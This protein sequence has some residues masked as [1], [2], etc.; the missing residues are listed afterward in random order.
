MTETKNVAWISGAYYQAK[1][2]LDKIRTKFEG[3]EFFDCYENTSFSNLLMWLSSNSCFADNRLVVVHSLPKMTESEKD[4]LK[5]IISNIT[6]NVWLIFFMIKPSNARAIF[7]AVKKSGKVYEFED[8]VPLSSVFDWINKRSKELGFE[9][10]RNAIEAIA[11]NSSLSNDKK[12]IMIDLLDSALQRLVLYSPGKKE[13]S[14]EDVILTS[15]FCNNFIIWDLMNAC[16]EKDYEAC[17]N[18][19][20][21]CS[22]AN[23]DSIKAINEI[24]PIMTWK[25]RMLIAMKD[26]L[27]NGSSFEDTI[28]KVSSIRKISLEGSGLGAITKTV[29]SEVSNDKSEVSNDKKENEKPITIWNQRAC[30]SAISSNYGR[31]SQIENYSRKELYL[32]VK[33]LEDCSILARACNSEAKAKLIADVVFMTI[34]SILDHSCI[35]RILKAISKR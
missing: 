9:L 20:N 26:M 13:Y 4:K 3:A 23:S 8:Y 7:N 16:E 35:S 1:P 21:K 6:D 5:S 19:F 17:L 34:C 18:A 25:Y 30:S 14:I 2:M 29:Y 11:E 32:I 22:M 33:C 10:P 28:L 15:V 27:A 12:G 24:L 31:K